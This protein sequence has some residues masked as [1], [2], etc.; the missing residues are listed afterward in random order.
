VV[1]DGH[2]HDPLRAR[3]SLAASPARRRRH[4]V[5]C[6]LL[7]L[8]DADEFPEGVL[9]RSDVGAVVYPPGVPST[10]F[11]AA[12]YKHIVYVLTSSGV[13]ALLFIV[14]NI[15]GW[16]LPRWIYAVIVGL[17]VLWAASVAWQDEHDA[18]VRL[19]TAR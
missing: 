19:G 11:L 10:A 13:A 9:S 3:S 1:L 5:G 8:A 15:V 17:G 4:D 18:V 2:A 16:H 12:L 7:F 6:S 14:E